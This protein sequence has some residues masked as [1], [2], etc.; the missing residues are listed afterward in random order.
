MATVDSLIQAPWPPHVVLDTIDVMVVRKIAKQ[1]SQK[2]RE[3]CMKN[4]VM[5]IL[6]DALEAK[7]EEYQYESVFM[8][9][10]EMQGE[11]CSEEEMKFVLKKLVE[12]NAVFEDQERISKKG[13]DP[14]MRKKY[15][16]NF[17][18]GVLSTRDIR[19]KYSVPEYLE[20]CSEPLTQDEK[21]QVPALRREVEGEFFGG[22][23]GCPEHWLNSDLKHNHTHCLR[24]MIL[25][26]PGCNVYNLVHDKAPDWEEEEGDSEE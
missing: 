5:M 18:Q 14:V 22:V 2:W 20:L 10:V 13:E 6:V 8:E 3:H 16:I 21:D 25:Y 1:R 24:D 12:E 15:Q 19:E 11:E 4:V 9:E 23:N 7:R 17:Q 26:R